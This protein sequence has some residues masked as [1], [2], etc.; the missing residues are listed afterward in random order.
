M[1]TE[2]VQSIIRELAH[3]NFNMYPECYQLNEDGTATDEAAM[4]VQDLA[5]NYFNNRQNAEIERDEKLG[6]TEIDY[7]NWCMDAFSDY[8]TE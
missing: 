6:I 2:N 5:L 8:I 3:D 7:V 4:T 1:K